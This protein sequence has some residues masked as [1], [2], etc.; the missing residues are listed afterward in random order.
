M[1]VHGLAGRLGRRASALLAVG[2]MAGIS[3]VA[4]APPAAALSLPCSGSW[5]NQVS[6]FHQG[7]SALTHWYENLE[8]DGLGTMWV[9]N[10]TGD[11]VERFD[12]AGSRLES[13]PADNPGA[14]RIKGGQLYVNHGN[15]AGEAL[16]QETGRAA[17]DRLDPQHPELPGVRF[18]S[19]L[20]MA[21][22]GAFDA[23]G[24]YYV[25]N[26]G[27][28]GIGPHDG[29]TKVRPDGS[30]D[31]AWNQAANQWGLNGAFVAGDTLYT[32][33][34]ADLSSPVTAIPLDDPGQARV[35]ARLSAALTKGL[36]DLVLGPDGYLYVAG[37]LSNELLRVNPS[38]GSHCV[39]ADHIIS[40]TGVRF[41]RFP[42]EDPAKVVYVT[43]ASGNIL[44]I[45]LGG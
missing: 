11:R 10:N 3:V 36:D 13:R 34:T 31:T 5:Q 44:R 45:E 1:R 29:V 38:T 22:G 27:S 41:S 15:G 19:G 4:G 17:V 30:L 32:T 20:K 23:A 26:T 28:T 18:A 42:G 8:F 40:P 16:L 21:N 24:N 37:F 25:T 6:V 14:V 43:K 35:I 2:A 33:S 39:V 7:G 9:S 12:S